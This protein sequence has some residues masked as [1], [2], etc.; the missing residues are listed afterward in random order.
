MKTA[1]TTLALQWR[2]T[3]TSKIQ[4]MA[5]KGT[6]KKDLTV[7]DPITTQLIKGALQTLQKEMESLIERTAMS[8][9]IREKKDFFSGV[10][11]TE[12]QLI[13]GTNIPVFGDLIR[14]LFERF[15]PREMFEG[16]IFWYNDCYGS[17]GGVSHTPDQVFV[18]PVFI[19]DSIVG[20]IQSWAHFSDV[21]GMRPGSLSPDATNI[22]QEGTIVPPVKLYARGVYNEDAFRIFQRNS[23]YPQMVLGDTRACVAAVRLGQQRL[24][25]ICKQHGKDTVLKTFAH[26]IAETES[27]DADR[28]LTTY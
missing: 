21:G 27:V 16:D 26:F 23:R 4:T 25:E 8:P 19:N 3:P 2:Q 9:F 22:H 24:L 28:K 20:F 1:I 6:R 18:A 13:V 14:P 7:T 15:S 5:F 10:F 11:D 12:G 17:H